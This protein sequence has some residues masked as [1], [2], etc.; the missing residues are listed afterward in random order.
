MNK[1]TNVLVVDDSALM[2]NLIS[3]MVK[4][5]PVL[6]VPVTAMNGKFALD[7]IK[8]FEIDCIVLDLEMPEMNGIEFLKERQKENIKIPVIILSSIAEKGA[9]I[10]M[11]ALSLGASDFILKP[12]GSISHD[13]HQVRD[14]LVNT[15]KIYTRGY[16]SILKPVT[17]VE[18]RNIEAP[19]IKKQEQKVEIQTDRIDVIALGI[20]T[21][22]PNALRQILPHLKMELKPPI[23]IVQHMP[24]GFT[25]EFAKSL[26]KICPLEVKE[27]E[28]G[29]VIKTGRI[30]I[31]PGNKHIVAE[32]KSLANIIR[33]SDSE[34]VNGHRPSV[35]TLFQSVNQVYHQN[36]MAI[37]MT[38]MGK[39]GVREMGEIYR[40]GGLTI[41]QTNDSC[42][43]PGMPNAAVSQGFV[44]KVISLDD[45]A[46]AINELSENIHKF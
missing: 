13:I 7:K 17:P 36:C 35:D 23:L 43:V 18:S 9:R 30:L 29:D 34:P 45:M 44:H 27:A 1:K 10:T 2:R 12:S 46:T 8:R 33:L 32:R 26:D 42:V 41:A 28:D 11:E 6:D 37:I 21:G 5:D 38:G 22:G 40:S 31:A 15:I 19:P 4:S 39:D 14:Q 20:S 24:A 16:R 3:K 25:Y